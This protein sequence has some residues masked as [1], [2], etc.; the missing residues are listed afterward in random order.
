[1]L[2]L[3]VNNQYD[4]FQFEVDE[5]II[6]N[7]LKAM[8]VIYVIVLLVLFLY[9]DVSGFL[10]TNTHFASFTALRSSVTEDS[11]G[12]ASQR[13][14]QRTRER[15]LSQR[16]YRAKQQHLS[17][18]Q[19]LVLQ[20]YWTQYGQDIAYHQR[21][22]RDNVLSLFPQTHPSSASGSVK[23]CLDI[24]F[25]SGD[26]LLA[27]AKQAPN[28]CF[29]GI[30]IHKASIASFL[31]KVVLHDVHNV[32][33]FRIDAADFIRR[34]C[35]I[36]VENP[37]FDE[38]S[39]YFPDPW[40]NEERDKERR[41]VRDNV[42]DSLERILRLPATLHV[43][44]DV[45]QYADH[46]KITIENRNLSLEAKKTAQWRL[47][48]SFLYGNASNP[49]ITSAADLTFTSEADHKVRLNR[50]VITKYEGKALESGSGIIFDM[51]YSLTNI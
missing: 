5:N 1:M 43:A 44:T 16:W 29:V 31:E 7:N 18:K 8:T 17:K 35:D 34:H 51:F 50:P 37:I 30:E 15:P 10:L 32:R 42:V 24:G 38:V 21:F 28:D 2:D 13:T 33:V 20:Q 12:T 6:E 22:S 14:A 39:V 3:A 4:S 27:R 47:K 40:P 45:R 9:P 23:L 25:G 26:A 19:R 46:V 41:I 49:N 11:F 48:D 36:Q